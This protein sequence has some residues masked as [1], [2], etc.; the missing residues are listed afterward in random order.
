MLISFS[1][2]AEWTETTG[3]IE[4]STYYIDMD[5]IKERSGY[6]FYWEFTDYY[7]PDSEGFMSFEAYKKADCGE[8]KSSI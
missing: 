6:V 8:N 5:T 3:S 7:K 1:S 4:G 2:I